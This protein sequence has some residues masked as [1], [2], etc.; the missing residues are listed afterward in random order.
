[1]GG[2]KKLRKC[3]WQGEQRKKERAVLRQLS[4]SLPHFCSNVYVVLAFLRAPAAVDLASPNSQSFS[5]PADT[6]SSSTCVVFQPRPADI[7]GQTAGNRRSFQSRISD[8]AR[9]PTGIPVM[10]ER[11]GPWG[12]GHAARPDPFAVRTQETNGASWPCPFVYS[13]RENDGLASCSS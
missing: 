5:S 4:I 12:G 13:S 7:A 8:I 3:P 11:G 1:M 9:P 10:R 2:D 6:S